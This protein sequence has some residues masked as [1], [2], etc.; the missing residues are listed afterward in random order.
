VVNAV[1]Y[2]TS[3]MIFDSLSNIDDHEII[4]R[5]GSQTDGIGGVGVRSPMPAVSR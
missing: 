4:A 5:H 1:A 2:D 3:P